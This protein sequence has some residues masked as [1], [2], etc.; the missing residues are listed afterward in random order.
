MR[1]EKGKKRERKEQET[2]RV[3]KKKKMNYEIGRKRKDEMK[4]REKK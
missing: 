4:S 3:R 1:N 2:I